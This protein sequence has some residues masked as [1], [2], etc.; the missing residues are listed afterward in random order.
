[1]NETLL[2][3]TY[4]VFSKKISLEKYKNVDAILD[5]IKAK[6]EAHPVVAYIGEFDHYAH[7]TNL[8]KEAVSI[9]IKE[10]KNIVFCF[11]KELKNPLVLSVRPRSIGVAKVEDG[12]VISFMKAPAAPAQEQMVKWIEEL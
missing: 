4:P 3:D 12:F 10:A 6:I 1:M 11:G 8:S 7:T 2:L 9:D 5:V